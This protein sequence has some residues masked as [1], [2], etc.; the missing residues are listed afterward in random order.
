MMRSLDVS[1]MEQFLDPRAS[2]RPYHGS[3]V[4]L[5]AQYET[6]A[7]IELSK[8]DQRKRRDKIASRISQE[9]VG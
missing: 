8:E 1:I 7:K 3:F 6:D 4:N 2:R 9:N 5:G